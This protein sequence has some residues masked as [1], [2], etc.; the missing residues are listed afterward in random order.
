MAIEW[1]ET[2]N[3][4]DFNMRMGAFGVWQFE[5]VTGIS[6]SF[7]SMDWLKGTFTIAP[8]SSWV[9][10]WFPIKIFPS[11]NALIQGKIHGKN[12]WI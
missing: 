9:K 5:L 7:K 2:S 6:C 10:P 1:E 3:Q 12:P 11:T 4:R 8:Y